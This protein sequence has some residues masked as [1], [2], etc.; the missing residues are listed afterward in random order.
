[1]TVEETRHCK[2]FTRSGAP[3]KAPPLQGSDYCFHHDPAM[4]R[5]RAVAKHKGGKNKAAMPGEPVTLESPLDVREGVARLIGDLWVMGNSTSRARALISAYELA[6]K[7]FELIEL[8]D[9]V[10]ALENSCHRVHG[11]GE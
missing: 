2:E 4:A 9:R 11:P 1:M 5:K 10:D 8:E 6:L 3:C 7:T